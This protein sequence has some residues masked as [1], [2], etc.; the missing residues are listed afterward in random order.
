MHVGLRHTSMMEIANDN[1]LSGISGVREGVGGW[2]GKGEGRGLED[3][4]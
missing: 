1:V 3:I 4:S 2:E